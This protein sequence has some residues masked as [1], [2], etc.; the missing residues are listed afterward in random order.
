M[1]GEFKHVSVGADLSQAEWESTS[2]HVL[3]SQAT[4]DII[5][6]SSATQLTRLGIGSSGQSLIVSGGIPAWALLPP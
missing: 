1:A 2:G 6:A 4:G 5:Y 3:N